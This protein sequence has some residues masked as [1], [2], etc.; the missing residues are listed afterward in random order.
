MMWT[1]LLVV[2]VETFHRYRLIDLV[3]GIEGLRYVAVAD[4]TSKTKDQGQNLDFD[5]YQL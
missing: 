1:D 2:L 5:I 4:W 3:I